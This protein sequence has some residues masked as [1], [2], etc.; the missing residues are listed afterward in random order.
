MID[1]E[2]MQEIALHPYTKALLNAVFTL[3]TFSENKVKLLSGE[4][5]SPL[6]VPEG[7]PFVNR[8]EYAMEIC[9]KEK[10]LLK[11]VAPDHKVAC[12]L[13]SRK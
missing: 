7:C 2:K 8:C 11:E 1:S 12:H 3:N 13:I 5:P 9:K 4:V 10:P 6:D